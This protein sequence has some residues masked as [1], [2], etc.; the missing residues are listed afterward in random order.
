VSI[1]FFLP[2]GNKGTR[3]KIDCPSFYDIIFLD[4]QNV[5]KGGLNEKYYPMK[6]NDYLLSAYSE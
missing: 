5:I 4:E 6:E 1:R 3:A 2:L